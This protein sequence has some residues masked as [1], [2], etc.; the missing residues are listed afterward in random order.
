MTETL[1]DVMRMIPEIKSNTPLD[2][3]LWISV[4][5]QSLVHLKPELARSYLIIN[6]NLAQKILEP[7]F[8]SQFKSYDQ[9]TDILTSL[10]A[11][12]A[13]K[14]KLL[15]L[16][17][18]AKDFAQGALEVLT[19]YNIK[20]MMLRSAFARPTDEFLVE[21]IMAKMNLDDRSRL[22]LAKISTLEVLLEMIDTLQA[23]KDEGKQNNNNN[24]IQA[25][26]DELKVKF[27]ALQQSHANFVNYE[28]RGRNRG[29]GKR[30]NGRGRGRGR[31]ASKDFGEAKPQA[32][33]LPA[34]C[35][36]CNLHKPNEGFKYCQKCF[37]DYQSSYRNQNN[38]GDYEGMEYFTHAGADGDNSNASL[39]DDGLVSE[40]NGMLIDLSKK[41]RFASVEG[42]IGD[43]KAERIIM[44]DTGASITLVDEG[45]PFIK[46]IDANISIRFGNGTTTI[47]K[48]KRLICIYVNKK[49][50]RAWAYVT[51][52]LPTPVILGMDYLRTRA[53]IDLVKNNIRL[54]SGC[55]NVSDVYSASKVDMVQP[56]KIEGTEFLYEDYPFMLNLPLGPDADGVDFRAL[57]LYFIRK[58]ADL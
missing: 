31:G 19:Y 15:K 49:P 37:L 18:E 20:L 14:A 4:V 28:G 32:D 25:E 47:A 53:V 44:I 24:S 7:T 33:K 29:R 13:S 56:T 21:K 9:S 16:E 6:S 41:T 17:D 5:D 35:I 2:I 10:K 50:F 55:T 1:P 45:M 22:G 48:F 36:K 26:Y 39:L 12:F 40:P 27:D 57:M 51:K 23:Q 42:T 46:Q 3:M 38:Y 30:G 8:Y 43:S 52:G 58:Y 34:L 11:R 54:F